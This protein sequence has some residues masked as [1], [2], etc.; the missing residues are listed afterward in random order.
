MFEQLFEIASLIQ[1]TLCW[2]NW[3][4]FKRLWGYRK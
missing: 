1:K 2:G 4:A 3:W